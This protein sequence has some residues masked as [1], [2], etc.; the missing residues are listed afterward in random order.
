[1]NP[2]I[3]LAQMDRLTDNNKATMDHL[4]RLLCILGRE[5]NGKIL[6]LSPSEIHSLKGLKKDMANLRSTIYDVLDKCSACKQT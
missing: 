5:L 6:A 2:D 4:S 3:Y 1:M